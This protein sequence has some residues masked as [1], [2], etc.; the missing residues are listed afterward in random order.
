MGV[1][2]TADQRFLCVA[3]GSLHQVYSYRIESDGSLADK[4]RYYFLHVDTVD[5]SGADGMCADRD[6]RVYVATQMGVQVCEAT[7]Q[8]LCILPTP[9][10]KVSGLCFGGADFN[11][12]YATC[13]DTVF[14]RKL[15]VHGVKP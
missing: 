15:R 6:G 9:K 7:G 12:L 2:F 14:Q 10:G 8:T 11:T 1:A 13:G 5:R 3:D 4:Q